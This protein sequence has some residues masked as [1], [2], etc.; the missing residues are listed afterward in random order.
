[1]RSRRSRRNKPRASFNSGRAVRRPFAIERLASPISVKFRLEIEAARVAFQRRS[2]TVK[3]F[4]TQLASAG[5]AFTH[6]DAQLQ[7][8]AHTCIGISS[9]LG[10]T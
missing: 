7:V 6:A 9:H 1:M 5:R 8:F 10:T 4:F 3:D 2:R